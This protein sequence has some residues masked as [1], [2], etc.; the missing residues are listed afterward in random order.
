IVSVNRR[1][2][3][4]GLTAG[5]CPAHK[6]VT[7]NPLQT[8]A[9]VL[10][11][12]AV[13]VPAAMATPAKPPKGHQITVMTRNLYLGTDLTPIFTAPNAP[14]MFAA[15]ASRWAQTQANDFPARAQALADEIAASEPDL[16]GLQEAMLFRTDVPPDGP[17]SP[18]GTVAYD[19]V[20]LLV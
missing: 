19:F 7:V 20:D 11:A 13:A 17:V 2:L 5:A 14:A 8:V 3:F 18:A 15:V 6:E 12:A 4:P 16:V 9:V 1:P 10:T